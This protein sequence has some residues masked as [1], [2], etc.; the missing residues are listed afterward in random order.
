L[1]V[2][3]SHYNV[4]FLFVTACCGCCACFRPRYKRLV[5]SIFPPDPNVSCICA[6]HIWHGF[7]AVAFLLLK[8]AKKIC[9]CRQ[10]QPFCSHYAGQP[11]LAGTLSYCQLKSCGFCYSS[12]T[13]CMLLLIANTALRLEEYTR[14]ILL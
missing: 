12:F 13:A 2:I 7:I 1:L 5:D 8:P 11:V 10:Q 6:L 9:N 4:L 14:V 3:E